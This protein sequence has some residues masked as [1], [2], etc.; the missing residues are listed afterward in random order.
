[1]GTWK[2][3]AAAIVR[4]QAGQ[5]LKHCWDLNLCI[6]KDSS[7]LGHELCVWSVPEWLGIW[8]LSSK[9]FWKVA[10]GRRHHRGPSLGFPSRFGAQALSK[11][12][13][14]HWTGFFCVNYQHSSSTIWDLLH[15]IPKKVQ[16]LVRLIKVLMS[17]QTCLSWSWGSPSWW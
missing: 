7:C 1:M 13:S 14:V 5:V 12:T 10:V 8:E 9:W 6:R 17:S 3:D 16:G 2:V 4:E 15:E 11:S